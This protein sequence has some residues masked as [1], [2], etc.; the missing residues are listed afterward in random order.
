M[1]DYNLNMVSIPSG[2]LN[3]VKIEEFEMC[4]T[5]VTWD[6]WEVYCKDVGLD[7]PDDA[8]FG[9]GNRPVVNVSWDDIQLYIKW[10]NE[11]TGEEYDLPTTEEW[12]YAC[13]A[14][15]TTDFYTG[16]TINLSQA[17]YYESDDNCVNKTM[18]VKSYPPNQWGLYEMMGNVWEW[19]SSSAKK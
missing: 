14:G 5:C 11:K 18:P 4:E 15:T 12:E 13:R 17:N 9:R 3:D 8:G 7:L 1:K 2:K 10:L 19:V 6:D 16:D